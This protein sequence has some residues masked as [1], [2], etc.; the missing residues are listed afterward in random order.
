MFYGRLKRAIH[1]RGINLVII[2]L[3]FAAVFF[4]LISSIPIGRNSPLADSATDLVEQFQST[5]L[6]VMRTAKS[7]SVRERYDKIFPSISKTFHM[8]LMAQIVT[9]GYWN[10]AHA[11][12]KAAATEAFKR[13]NIATLA[14][15]FD[16]YNGEV[17][18]LNGEYPGPS[19]TTVV[20]TNLIKADKS[21]VSVAYVARKFNSDWRLIDVVVDD[22]ISELKIRRSEYH[23]ILS[24]GGL[25]ALTNLLNNKADELMSR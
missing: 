21:K 13:I 6:H 19:N 22:G 8:P 2:R 7:T 9:V 16:G 24:N 23:L 4:V 1:I 3:I 20:S 25:S 15:L 18:E 10:K 17:F 14:T 12:E 5:L 11:S